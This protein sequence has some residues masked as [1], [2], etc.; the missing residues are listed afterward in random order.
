[1]YEYRATVV[2][3]YDGDTLHADVDLG[4]RVT[5]RMAFRL[6][7]INTPELHTGTPESKLKGL[8]ARMALLG[9]VLDKRVLIRSH[10]DAQEKYGRYLA[11]IVTLDAPPVNVNDWMVA[12]GHAE[13][14]MRDLP[15]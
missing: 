4:F 5:F 10:K 13:P 8:A 1:M 15:R 2:A 3:V 12:Q 11:E 6:Y 7:G 14:Y 9:L